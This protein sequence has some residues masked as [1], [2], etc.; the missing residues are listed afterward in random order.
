MNQ[1]TDKEI[2]ALTDKVR[3]RLAGLG[4]EELELLMEITSHKVCPDTDSLNVLLRVLK[5]N[6]RQYEKWGEQNHSVVEWQGILMEEVGEQA[7]EANDYY[8]EAPVKEDGK[9]TA[10]TIQDGHERLERYKTELVQVMA[11]CLNM[12]RCV[13][14]GKFDALESVS[15]KHIG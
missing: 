13:D 6:Q 5:E 2:I 3:L 15:T 12:L 10:P 4:T 8:F 7:K 9:K 1:K 14:R 11:V